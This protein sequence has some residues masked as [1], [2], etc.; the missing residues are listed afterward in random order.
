MGEGKREKVRARED[1]RTED[2]AGTELGTVQ[3]IEIICN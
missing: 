3:L 1:K 2:T